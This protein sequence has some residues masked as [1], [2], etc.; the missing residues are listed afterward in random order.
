MK[1]KNGNALSGNVV[2]I[3]TKNSYVSASKGVVAVIGCEDVIVVR[4][5]G[6][7]LV[8]KRDQV[9]D[10]KKVV[11]SLKRKKLRKYI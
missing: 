5:K 6:V 8:C 11:D 2:A 10:V 4:E 3:D 1:D 7:T 9:E